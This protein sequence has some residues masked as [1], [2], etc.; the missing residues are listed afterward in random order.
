MTDNDYIY[1]GPGSTLRPGQRL[2]SAPQRITNKK[3]SRKSSTTKRTKRPTQ[4]N[5]RQQ[6]ENINVTIETPTDSTPSTQD[7]IQNLFKKRYT[8]PGPDQHAPYGYKLVAYRDQVYPRISP[9]TKEEYE[10]GMQDGVVIDGWTDPSENALNW[11]MAGAMPAARAGI[12]ALG[13]AIPEMLGFE[14]LYPYVSKASSVVGS[15][16]GSGAARLAA[17]LGLS[18]A[19]NTAGAQQYSKN[20]AQD[21]PNITNGEDYARY[22]RSIADASDLQNL[23]INQLKQL[24]NLDPTYKFDNAL[25]AYTPVEEGFVDQYVL[26]PYNADLLFLAPAVGYNMT[27]PVRDYR[28]IDPEA[29]TEVYKQGQIDLKKLPDDVKGKK[30]GKSMLYEASKVPKEALVLEN[31]VAPKSTSIST[32]QFKHP[33]IHAISSRNPMWWLTGADVLYHLG[34]GLA[35]A[36]KSTADKLKAE[37]EEHALDVARW[38]RNA[39]EAYYSDQVRRQF[40]GNADSGITVSQS[41]VNS[42]DSVMPESDWLNYDYDNDTTTNDSLR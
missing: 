2:E 5:V 23:N 41:D 9:I 7:L 25:E 33:K 40:N 20:V 12:T 14:T 18:A 1:T 35:G 34:A 28:R 27:S 16:L 4:N 29:K 10:S 19:A 38:A 22:V 26:N 42:S 8:S 39:V 37:Q 13:K 31:N 21:F 17:L 15:T 11:M 3:S 24:A 6:K 32:R 36:Y 30:V